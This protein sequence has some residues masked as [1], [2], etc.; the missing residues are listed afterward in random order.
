MEL[1]SMY[2]DWQ[3]EKV[4]TITKKQV[5]LENSFKIQICFWYYGGRTQICFI[6]INKEFRPK[7][8]FCKARDSVGSL[9]DSI[10]NQDFADSVLMYDAVTD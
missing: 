2:R 9:S 3:E 7:L 6:V 1:F 10:L 8:Q 4:Q 5:W